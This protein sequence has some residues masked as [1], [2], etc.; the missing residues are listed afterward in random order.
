VLAR[1]DDCEV[2]PE[3]FEPQGVLQ[4]ERISP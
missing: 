2:R 3:G 1:Q 4:G